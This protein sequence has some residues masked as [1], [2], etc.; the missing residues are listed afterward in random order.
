MLACV[1]TFA[2]EGITPR[3]VAVEVDVR[4]GLPAF[5]V[6]GL[7]DRAVRESR[8]RVRAAIQNAGWS[9]PQQRVTV[10]L[11][12]AD[13]R[14]EGPGFDLA[15]ACGVLAA[16]GAVPPEV[17]TTT[18][19]FGELALSGELR[20]CRGAL[21]VAEG[22][23]EAGLGSMILPADQVADAQIVR[24]IG[25]VGAADLKEVAAVLCGTSTGRGPAAR[26]RRSQ[27][28]GPDLAD[29]RGHAG[30]VR[31]LTIAAAG[32][33]HLLLSGPPG[34]GKT[35]LAR[36]LPGILPPLTPQAELE[37]LRIRSVSGLPVGD[38]LPVRPFRA[39]HHTISAAGLV[40]GGTVPTPGEVTLAH[41]GVLFL[42]EL[43]EF[44]RSALE[45]LRQPLE[46]GELTIV[47]GQRSVTYPAIVQLVAATNPCPC[48]Y[49]GSPRC[50][51]GEADV[52]QYARKLSGPLLDRLDLAADV[53]RPSEEQLAGPPTMTTTQA[54]AAVSAARQRQAD[55]AASGSGPALNALLA[56]AELRALRVSADAH[57]V[58]RR[59]YRRGMLSPRGRGRL[60]RVA[61]TIA[62]LEARDDIREAD[63]L[64]ALALRPGTAAEAVAA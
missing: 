40:G 28:P 6:V 20:A 11:A 22:A 2:L 49:A 51:C 60:L 35:M 23:A 4:P 8:E 50:R 37:V 45:A 13:L 34:T 59:A 43:A 36:R 63:V 62:D 46:D 10:N 17:L 54:A 27:Q 38:G 16:I 57:A 31:A 12:P 25:I 64:E 41:R 1:T 55:R 9:F 7:G 42:D 58:I 19:I 5:T 53:Q 56:D 24:G 47:R 3:R 29:V 32:G 14:K 15:I 44:S 52:E 26:P 48:G 30:P 61:R 18:A 33:H 39:P 21:A